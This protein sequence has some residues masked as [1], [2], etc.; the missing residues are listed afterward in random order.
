M[1]GER[2]GS[3]EGAKAM[4]NGGLEG[5]STRDSVADTFKNFCF[6]RCTVQRLTQR[7]GCARGENIENFN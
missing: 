5:E 3:W 6:T 2:E 7:Q 4:S 1:R